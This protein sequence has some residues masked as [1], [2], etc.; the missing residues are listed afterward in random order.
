MAIRQKGT[1]FQVDVTVAGVRTPRV[2]CDTKTEALRV[3]ADFR[4]KLM[5]G[6]PP[7]MLVP[8]ATNAATRKGTLGMAV[9][10]AYKHQWQGRK[11]EASSLR[12]AE[13]W[14]LELDRDFPLDKLTSEVIGEVCDGWGASGNAAGTIN[15]K[16]AALSVM[17]KLAVEDGLLGPVEI[18]LE[19]MTAAVT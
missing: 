9:E 1:K 12:S 8:S 10:V 5:A 15:R 4:A 14:C 3:E 2:S 19:L 7:D 16:L 18:H 6:V 17:L 13:A 11:A